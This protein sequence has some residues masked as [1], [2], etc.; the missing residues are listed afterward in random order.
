[1]L[2]ILNVQTDIRI[3]S[4]SLTPYATL[5]ADLPPDC[6]SL[7]ACVMA[8]YVCHFHTQSL[9]FSK[10]DFLLPQ[11][12]RDYLLKMIIK[13]RSKL[14]IEVKR[15]KVLC[16]TMQQLCRVSTMFVSVQLSKG[17]TNRIVDSNTS[18]NQVEV[19]GFICAGVCE[20]EL[21]WWQV[22]WS[23]CCCLAYQLQLC[24]F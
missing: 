16:S 12:L 7:I 5:P 13:E 10:T 18:I 11:T 21:H 14:L 22:C 24:I 20:C 2:K 4:K 15:V 17:K 6:T 8:T 19:P 23:C 3:E 9:P 1:M